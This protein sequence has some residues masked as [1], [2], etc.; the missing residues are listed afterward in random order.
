M[1]FDFRKMFICY[2]LLPYDETY[3]NTKVR[4]EKACANKKNSQ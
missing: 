2:I 1:K 3:E 4:E